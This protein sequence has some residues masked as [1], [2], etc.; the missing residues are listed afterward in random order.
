MLDGAAPT[1]DRGARRWRAALRPE[2]LDLELSDIDC[3]VGRLERKMESMRT[4]SGC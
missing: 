4:R 2:L 3:N 1:E